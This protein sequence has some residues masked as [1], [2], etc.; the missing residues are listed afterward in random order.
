LAT[1]AST[2]LIITGVMSKP[3]PSPFDVGNDRLVG[4]LSEKSALTVIFCPPGGHLDV[5][6]HVAWLRASIERGFWNLKF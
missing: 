2:T 4:T 5:L 1:A 3:V 6:V